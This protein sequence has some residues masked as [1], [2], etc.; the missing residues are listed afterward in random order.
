MRHH[1]VAAGIA[2]LD[3][4]V[5]R[6]QTLDRRQHAR[7][8][9]VGSRATQQPAGAVGQAIAGAADPTFM[10]KYAD[11][12][13]KLIVPANAHIVRYA[14]GKMEDLEPGAPFRMWVAIS[15][16]CGNPRSMTAAPIADSPPKPV[17]RGG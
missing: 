16:W 14:P 5:S 13:K 8:G 17:C 3:A 9:I 10:I 11:G 4:I 12:E 7:P 15:G 1:R 6:Q 2:Q